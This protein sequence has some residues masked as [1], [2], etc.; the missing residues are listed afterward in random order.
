MKLVKLMLMALLMGTPLVAPAGTATSAVAIAAVAQ[1]APVV[2]QDIEMAD[3]LRAEGKIY[4]VV[5]TLVSI[6]AGMFVYLIMLDKKVKKLEK[7]L[8]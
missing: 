6:L 7:T 1:E 3:T 2:G 8:E 5:L 4:V